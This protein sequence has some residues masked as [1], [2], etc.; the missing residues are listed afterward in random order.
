MEGSRY[1]KL[2]VPRGAVNDRGDRKVLLSDHF[3]DSEAS[4]TR[5]LRRR[6]SEREG[7]RGRS[8]GR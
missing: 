2:R 1:R 7:T 8:R 3:G 6:L 5:S 4:S